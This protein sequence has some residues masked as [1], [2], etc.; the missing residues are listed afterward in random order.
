[1]KQSLL[2]TAA[3]SQKRERAVPKR[4][5][6]ARREALW[7]YFFISP[8]I[9]GFLV[10][11]LFP[12]LAVLYLSF[13]E[14]TVLQPPQWVGLKNYVDMFTNDRLFY[15]SLYNTVYY[16]VLR[17]PSWLIVG[18]GLAILLNRKILGI[19]GLRAVFYLPTIIPVVAS[20]IIWMWLLNPQV[21]ILNPTLRNIGII[22]PN[23]LH[24]QVWAKPAIV[25]L[26]VWQVGQ[27][28]MIFLAGLQEIPDVLYEA[29]E[30]DGAN[31][32]QKFIHVTL[33]MMT[34]I[35]YFNTVIGIISAFQVFGFAFIVT[36]GGPVNSTLFYVLY[37]YRQGFE[38]LKMGYASGMAVI[39]FLFILALTIVVV[40]TSDKWV[41]YERI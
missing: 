24:D 17:I 7:G 28:M 25:A 9:L 1:M 13:T 12:I 40:R 15:T 39:L 38:F 6:A 26:G 2:D 10:F 36:G 37:L 33:P 31:P 32:L 35:I 34:P 21:G 11:S 16:I 4:G 3:N 29:A 18:L 27:T 30:I 8:W 5:T 19:T 23:W 14:Y 20:S 22:V 41:Q